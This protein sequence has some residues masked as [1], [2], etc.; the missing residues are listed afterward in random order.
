M[1][2]FKKKDKP[3]PQPPAVYFDILPGQLVTVTITG[4]WDGRQVS[5]P[6]NSYF[7]LPAGRRQ[8]DPDVW[9]APVKELD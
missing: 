7:Q 8:T 2:L 4:T 3:A 9:V 1:R 5:T 6:H